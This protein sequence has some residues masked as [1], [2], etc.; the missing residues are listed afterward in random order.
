MIQHF[1]VAR[2]TMDIDRVKRFYIDLVG[3]KLL[4]EFN[5]DGYIGV[6]LGQKDDNWHLEFTMSEKKPCHCPDDEDV[7][8][9]YFEDDKGYIEVLERFKFDGIEAV[10]SINPYWDIHGRTYID[11]DGY[12]VVICHKKWDN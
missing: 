4:Y 2:H 11:P 12:R 10:K 7:L 3:L 5:H 6:M 9:F 8:V 1:R